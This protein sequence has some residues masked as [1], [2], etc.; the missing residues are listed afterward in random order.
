MHH[1]C[2]LLLAA[3]AW[4][5]LPAT[6]KGQEPRSSLDRLVQEALI[7]NADVAAALARWEAARQEP[8]RVGSLVDPEL[9]VQVIRFRDRGLGLQSEGETWY[10]LRQSVPFPG[11]LGLRSGVARRESE[12]EGRGYDALR[13]DLVQA[14]R[15]AYYRV[16]HAGALEHVARAEFRPYMVLAG[17]APDGVPL[18]AG[19]TPVDGRP[20]AYVCQD[21]ACRRPVTEPAE[22]AALLR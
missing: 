4:T 14:V 11:K 13:L 5:V 20:A 19:R 16:V 3:M 21:F 7:R 17:G 6:S 15:L 1:T 22:L 10:S 8:A 9:M 12:M 18:L 2:V